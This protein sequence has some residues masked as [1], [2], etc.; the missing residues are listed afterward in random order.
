VADPEWLDKMRS[1][2]TISRRSGDRVAEG[3]D[4]AG[5]R[6]KAVTDE[7]NNTVTQ[8][9]GDRQ[10]VHIRAPQVQVATTTREV[11]E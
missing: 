10:D 11:R 1:I 8:R 4:E 7:L 6:F 5:R 3:R 2:G 9:H